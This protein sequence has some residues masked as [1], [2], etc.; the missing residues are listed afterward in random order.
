M[1]DVGLD[2]NNRTIRLEPP[3]PGWESL[4]HP[5]SLPP[6]CSPD[7]SPLPSSLQILTAPC[8]S[9]KQT[10][11]SVPTTANW[12]AIH[13]MLKMAY[14]LGIGARTCPTMTDAIAIAHPRTRSVRRPIAHFLHATGRDAIR[15]VV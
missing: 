3:R 8:C 9:K 12:T 11:Y 7:R 13:I 5:L 14:A 2:D 6:S 4:H 15:G 10:T 1:R